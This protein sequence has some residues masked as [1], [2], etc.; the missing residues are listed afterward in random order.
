MTVDV[1][2]IGGGPAGAAAA[3]LLASWHYRVLLLTRPIDRSRGLAE[4]LPPSTHKLLAEI[5]VLDEV[6][7]AGFYRSTGNTVYWASREPRVEWFAAPGHQV[8]RPDFDRLLIDSAAKA[9][10]DVR[11]EACVTAV[12]L[13][14]GSARVECDGLTPGDRRQTTLE[15]RLVIDASGRRGIVG[16]RHRQAQSGFRTCAIV[17]VWHRDT[18]GLADSTHTV[19]ESF[20]DG[21][22]WSVPTSATLR[23]VGVMVA[24]PASYEG[25]IAKTH[26]MR[27]L[28]NGARLRCTFSCDASLYSAAR[29]A[30][31]RFLLVGD[32]GSFIDPLSSCGVKKALASAWV[33]AVAANTMLAHPER[34][35]A[36]ID[37]FNEWERGAYAGHLNRSREFAAAAVTAHPR[38][39]WEARAAVE[40]AG[41]RTATASAEPDASNV[42]VAFE[43]IR[44]ASS[45]E[46][47]LAENA[48][49]EPRPVI[50]GREIVLEDALPVGRFAHDV[51]LVA[52]AEIACRHSRVPDVYDDY[53]RTNAA[54]PLPSVVSGLSL[55]V[56]KGILHAKT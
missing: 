22:A 26:A 25:Q 50:R 30:D 9:G 4:S 23:Q 15:C 51:D 24:T 12:R 11:L 20:D 46:F 34:R 13:E 56:A 5:G 21:W 52:L 28:V 44:S 47:A 14:P 39:F 31:S 40:T 43:R 17:G 42:H 6:Q 38:P 35:P 10:V 29:Y 33:G 1:V 7:Q 41:P 55:L 19:V 8:F 49:F 27:E 54:A 37:F 36:A 32:A 16:R 53:C 3:R 45:I 18:W 48:R 2:V